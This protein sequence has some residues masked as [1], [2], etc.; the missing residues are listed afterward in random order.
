MQSMIEVIP[1][2]TRDLDNIEC[3]VKRDLFPYITAKG[4]TSPLA[5]KTRLPLIA[6]QLLEEFKPDVAALQEVDADHWQDVLGPLTEDAGYSHVFTSKNMDRRGHGLVIMWKKNLFSLKKSQN[7]HFDTHPLIQPTK[8]MPSTGNV[9]QIVAL[10]LVGGRKGIIV[11]N[12][13]LYWRPLTRYTR[14]RQLVALLTDATKLQQDLLQQA[15]EA[16][17]PLFCG[18]DY[19]VLPTEPIYQ[20]LTSRLPL[21]D[22]QLSVMHATDLEIT[23]LS[24]QDVNAERSVPEMLK[25]LEKIPVLHSAYSQYQSWDAEH[26][27][28]NGDALWTGEPF[29]TNYS[30]FKGTLD[31]IMTSEDAVEGKGSVSLQHVLSL[32]AMEH[33]E[34]EQPTTSSEL[35]TP[36]DAITLLS[37]TESYQR[38]WTFA[39]LEDA[40]GSDFL[41]DGVIMGVDEAGR[42]PVLGPMVYA[43]AFVPVSKRDSVTTLGVDDSKK[44]TDT[45][46]RSIFSNMTTN[47]QDWMGWAVT[48]ISPRDI[49]AGMFRRA[50]YNLNQ[51]A[52]ETTVALV[53]KIQ[54]MNIR[55]EE[56]YVDT[57]G[58]DTTYQAYLK[59][60]LFGV[61]KIT[62]A[63]KADSKYP[64]VSA[65]SIF[66]KVTRDYMVENWKF[67]EREERVFK[68]SR[69]FGSGYPGDPKTVAWL[70]DSMHEIFGYPSIV[71]FSWA[72]CI[73][74]LE[75]HA[76]TV[77]WPDNDDKDKKSDGTR[78]TKLPFAAKP[79]TKVNKVDSGFADEADDDDE[80]NDNDNNNNNN[81]NEDPAA[82]EEEDAP[83]KTGAK[84][85]R[86]AAG[87]K[88][89]AAP[90]KGKVGGEDEEEEERSMRR[91]VLDVVLKAPPQ[92]QLD[93]QRD[94]FIRMSG[95]RHL[96]S[97]V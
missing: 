5:A 9:S 3:L 82:E 40:A 74:R 57:V 64:I 12:H 94:A 6:K 79:V 1:L 52:H 15:A 78:Q 86:Q 77:I 44:L 7:I 75:K 59:D 48:A 16:G 83:G 55:I 85:K 68:L 28:F 38:T 53:K 37:Q 81:E 20:I 65:A 84:R 56:L 41:K 29:Y 27:A 25:L 47:H 10:E 42:G 90:K 66:A 88:A 67:T 95:F 61:Q 22:A 33:L 8:I 46:R 4:K 17:W 89:K 24:P 92:L 96:K 54:A 14:L 49:S 31:Y 19:N 72:T 26:K 45:T 13:H 35:K 69:E 32:P 2:L 43:V 36:G 50:K 80:E 70:R 91:K 18:G 11:T 76:V 97:L 73:Q 51:Q 23:G 93:L 21:T 30:E 62:V 58:K 39:S 71:R 63:K 60:Q 34:P 87:G